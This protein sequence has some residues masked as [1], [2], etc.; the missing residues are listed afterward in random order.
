MR[1]AVE[2]YITFKDYGSECFRKYYSKTGFQIPSTGPQ[3]KT[4]PGSDDYRDKSAFCSGC[5]LWQEV[6]SFDNP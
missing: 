2:I 4:A 3:P 5:P 1:F 6:E